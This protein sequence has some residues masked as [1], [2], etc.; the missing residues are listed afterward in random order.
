MKMKR[1]GRYSK[2]VRRHVLTISLANQNVAR[3]LP[4]DVFHV[5]TARSS[6]TVARSAA[7]D[8]GLPTI[9]RPENDGGRSLVV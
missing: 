6:P 9:V 8:M 5:C 7:S 3:A 1:R 4:D 2:A